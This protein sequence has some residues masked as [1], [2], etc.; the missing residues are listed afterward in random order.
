M[1]PNGCGK[2]TLL[3]AVLEE[4]APTAGTITRGAN[5]KIGYLD[6]ARGEL[7]P[8]ETVREAA[9]GDATEIVVGDEQLSVGSYLE[10]FLFDR[11]QQRLKIAELSGGEKA[12]VC[13][14]RLLSQ[15]CNLLMLD[16]PTNDLDV[17]T[18]SALESMLLD[19]GG[20]LILVSHDRWLLDRL[21][22]G[23]L[24]FEGEGRVPVSYTHLTLPTKA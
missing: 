19:F 6:Q 4:L 7:D 8:R 15:R 16:E 24:A 9:V 13:L 18:L 14:A 20:S 5:T 12:R 1:G 3:L 22:T 21:T 11:R 2:T 23:I 10:R 17:M